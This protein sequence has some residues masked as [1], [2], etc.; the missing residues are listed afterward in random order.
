MGR[1]TRDELFYGD[2][3]V[4]EAK[5]CLQRLA[6]DNVSC[7]YVDGTLSLRGQ[8]P[9]YYHKQKVQEAVIGLKGVAEVRNEIEVTSPRPR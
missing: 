1:T 9:S 5:L 2:D 3:L 8:V 7:T 6:V 4:E